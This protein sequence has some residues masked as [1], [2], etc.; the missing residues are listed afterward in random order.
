[1][2]PVA[3]RPE[4]A[5][6]VCFLPCVETALLRDPG[7]RSPL[8]NRAGCRQRVSRCLHTVKSAGVQEPGAG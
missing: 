4:L 3:L 5:W 2:P 8:G 6:K 7:G 1:M